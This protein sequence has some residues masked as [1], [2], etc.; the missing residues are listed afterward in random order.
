MAEESV[1]LPKGLGKGEEAG[2]FLRDTLRKA[3]QEMMTEEVAAIVGAGR[4]ERTEE[5]TTQRNGVRHRPFDTRLGTIDLAIP[6]LRTGSYFPAW[7]EPR[8]RAEQ[9]L[10][11]VV[12][13]AYLKGVSTRK[14][15]DLV[16]SLG[17]AGMSK[18]E[19]SR[20]CASLDAQVSAFRTRRLDGE[21]PYLFLDARYEHVREDERVQSM[22]VV[23]AYGIRS[24]GVREV[25]ALD[26]STA[27]DLEHWRG[28]LQD[29]VARGV[30]GVKLVTSDAHPGLKRAI[31]EVFL[32]A[33]WQR[34]RVHFVRNP[35]Q[36]CPRACSRWWRRWCGCSAGR[37]A[38]RRCRRC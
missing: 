18:S 37:S 19:V 6:N 16:Q 24:D 21:Y 14:V 20:L 23:I 12:A 28:F 15:E 13:E 11:A 38:A 35:W 17:I 36:E 34:C 26:V 32:G 31:A 8:R 9:A 30:R 2:D 7:L 25:L 22:A 3:L 33:G 27:E 4:Y 10:V 5:R 1:A 29:L